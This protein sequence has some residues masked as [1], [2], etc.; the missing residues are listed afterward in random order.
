MTDRKWTRRNALNAVA[1]AGAMAALPL[2]AQ[3]S[4]AS[5][6]SAVAPASGN[7]IRIGQSAHLTG[8]LGPTFL[9]VIKGQEWAIEETNR[10][11]GIQGRPVKLITLDDAYDAKKCVENVN[12]LIDKEKVV[13]LF[14]LA[15]SPNI[16]ATLPILAEKKVPLIGVYSGLP[17]LRTKQ[18]PYFFTTMASY[19]DEIAQ[20]V[21]NLV[22]LQKSN[23]GL[24]YQNAPFGQMM[25]PVVEEVVK[26]LGANL[27]ISA[28]LEANGSDAVA[29]AQSLAAAKPQA[30]MFMAFGPSMV[31]FVKAA[32]AYV[33]VPIYAISIANSPAVLKALGDDARGL[34]FTQLVPYPFR[35]TTALTRDLGAA[36]QRADVEVAYDYMFGYLNMRILLEALRRTGKQITSA[37]LVKAM[38]G[39]N[40]LDM[41]G[42]P[43]S[44]SPTKHH[45]SN[46]VEITI[47]GPGG[48][49]LR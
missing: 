18:H 10:K 30:I 12:T 47:V 32:R 3:E 13:A 44:Y 7:E 29:C 38:E 40:K 19:R 42:Y 39:M 2:R 43:L 6:G 16:I 34:A 41:G 26:E 5:A 31:G 14:G 11:G 1:A 25:K 49:W 27:V 4:A 46:F 22:T 28:P 36:A 15:S 33:G 45:G 48:R 24:V 9:P 21:R 35:Q 8:P 17:A 20:M 23:I 37:N